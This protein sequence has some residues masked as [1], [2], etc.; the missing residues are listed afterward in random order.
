[1]SGAPLHF[2][3]AWCGRVR[4]DQGEFRDLAQD[5]IEAADVTHGICPDCLARETDE[6]PAESREECR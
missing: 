6:A 4:I 3:C 1:V 5:S 2:V